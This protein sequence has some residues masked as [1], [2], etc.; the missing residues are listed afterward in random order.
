MSTTGNEASL[1]DIAQRCNVSIMTVS[2]AFRNGSVIHPETRK[3]ILAAAEELH[4]HRRNR[5]FGGV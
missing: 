2:R 3:R 4:Y 1:K 5:R